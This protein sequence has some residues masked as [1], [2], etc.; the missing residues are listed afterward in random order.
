MRC[1]NKN[2]KFLFK[3]NSLRFLNTVLIWCYSISSIDSSF[4][5]SVVQNYTYNVRAIK[6][7]ALIKQNRSNDRIPVSYGKVYMYELQKSFEFNVM[8]IVVLNITPII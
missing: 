1:K 6:Y 2:Y 5:Y 3:T 8:N 7:K 4:D